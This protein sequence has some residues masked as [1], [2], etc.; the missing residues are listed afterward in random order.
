V[1]SLRGRT[2]LVTGVLDQASIAWQVA[3]ALQ[4]N[5]GR[6]LLT[7][8]GRTQRIAERAARMLPEQPEILRLDVTVDDDHAALR[9][10][11]RRRGEPIAGLVHAIAGMRAQ[12]MADGF[13]GLSPADAMHGFHVSAFSLQ[14]LAT[15]LAPV[16]DR[17]RGAGIVALTV[18]SA[19]ALPGYDW[20]GVYKSAL[21][22]IARYLA[23]YLGP[24]SIRV[25]LVASGLLETSPPR[26]SDRS[27]PSP[28]TTRRGRRWD[29]AAAI[30][31]RWS[32]PCCSCCP[33]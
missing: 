25:N 2:Y 27:P 23:L 28:N 3:E 5:G 13:L 10:E 22:S 8:Y 9:E 7:S 26:E 15:A 20:M 30:R 32:A 18:D 6:V 31:S 17:D 19:R 4:R 14:Q 16:L 1:L 21:E 29:G 33:N 12:A 24:E 11:L